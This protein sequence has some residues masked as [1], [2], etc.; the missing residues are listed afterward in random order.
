[1][2]KADIKALIE[3]KGSTLAELDRLFSL[4][5]GATRDALRRKSPNAEMAIANFLEL[6]PSAVFPNR[7]DVAGRRIDRRRNSTNVEAIA[8]P[9][10]RQPINDTKSVI[11]EKSITPTQGDTH[12]T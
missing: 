7:Y 10:S 3:K 6:S 12:E 4:P 9:N 8:N 2:H 5:E 1:M 11:A